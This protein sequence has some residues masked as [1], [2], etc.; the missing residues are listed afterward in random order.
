M[1]ASRNTNVSGSGQG[2]KGLSDKVQN[3]FTDSPARATRH[4]QRIE[5]GT[6]IRGVAKTALIA[7]RS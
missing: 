4:L 6:Q 5:S 3:L 1:A 7:L 2:L